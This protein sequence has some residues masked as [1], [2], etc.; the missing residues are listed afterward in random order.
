MCFESWV[1]GF[2]FW[3]R[4]VGFGFQQLELIIWD[5]MWGGEAIECWL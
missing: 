5:L 2:E 4:G 1:S 3:V